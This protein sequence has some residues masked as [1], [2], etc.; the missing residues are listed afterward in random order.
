MPNASQGLKVLSESETALRLLCLAL[1]TAK[2]LV[3]K[4]TLC[5][6]KRQIKT[7]PNGAA[8]YYRVL[9]KAANSA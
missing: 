4:C 8:L 3:P 9:A 1:T 5:Y 7:A 2:W 6:Q